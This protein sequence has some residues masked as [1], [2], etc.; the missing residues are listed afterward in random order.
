MSFSGDVK[1]ELAG[2]IYYI[3]PEVLKKNIIQNMNENNKCLELIV[4]PN[5]G[6][7]C[8][9]KIKD[10]FYECP[11]GHDIMNEMNKLKI[12]IDI[13]KKNINGLINI[14][15]SIINKIEKFYKNNIKIF[16]YQ[17]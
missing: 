8:N 14:F 16:I 3:A 17:L 9:M 5:C 13:L 10:N 15:E 12:K 4:C 2:S 6:E 7:K 1:D 11:N